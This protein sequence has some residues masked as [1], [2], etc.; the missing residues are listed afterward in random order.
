MEDKEIIEEL[1]KLK[2]YCN[3]KEKSSKWDS[4]I[5]QWQ[6]SQQALDSAIET[7]YKYID[8]CY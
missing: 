7:V 1:E 3:S 8:L 6:K 2:K 4:D 5:K